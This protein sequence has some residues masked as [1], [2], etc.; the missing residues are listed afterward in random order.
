MPLAE[1]H[2]LYATNAS[3]IAR[4]LREVMEGMVG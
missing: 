3:D 1:V 4:M 2:T